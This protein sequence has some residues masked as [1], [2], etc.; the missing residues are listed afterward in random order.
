M[1]SVV[2]VIALPE[3]VE[4]IAGFCSLPELNSLR[5]INRAI[6]FTLCGMRSVVV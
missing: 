6:P 2:Q 5:Q 1:E 3:L 4:V